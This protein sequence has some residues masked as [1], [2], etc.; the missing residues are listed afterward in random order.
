MFDASEIG[1]N[2]KGSLETLSTVPQSK[3]AFATPD[4]RLKEYTGHD[5]CDF[6]F[7]ETIA[8]NTMGKLAW[9]KR[10]IKN[11]FIDV[12]VKKPVDHNH[13][14]QEAVIQWLC[15]KTLT[16]YGLGYHCPNVYD[17]YSKSGSIWFSMSPIYNAPILDAYCITLPRWGSPRSE[18]GIMLFKI[19]SQIAMCCFVLEK[20]IGF[21]HRDLKPD[22]ILVKLDKVKEHVL[23][24]DKFDIKVASSP[25]AILVDFG[26]SCLGPGKVPWIQAGSGVLPPLD[27]CPKVGR[28]IFMLLVFLLWRRDIRDSLITEHQD[29][30]KSSL[31]LTKERWSQMMSMRRNPIHWIYIL[32]TERDF[33]CPALD[34]IVWLRSCAAAYPEVVSI[35]EH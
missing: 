7:E 26:F 3:C 6:I 31:N 9:A 8:D 28:D 35:R 34:P 13:T 21:N 1:L 30:L 25:T 4:N 10:R 18:N 16:K 19:L 20:S 33:H 11:E 15:N 22:N 32:I 23:H 17:I 12:L 24:W 29:F 14:K 2:W 27:P 5:R